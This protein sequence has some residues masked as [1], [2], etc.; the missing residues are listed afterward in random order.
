MAPEPYTPVRIIAKE[1]VA[2]HHRAAPAT[3]CSLDHCS[4]P[5]TAHRRGFPSGGRCR[6]MPFTTRF[7]SSRSQSLAAAIDDPLRLR[8]SR[9]ARMANASRG[10][11]LAAGRNWHS[12]D[13]AVLSDIP[14]GSIQSCYCNRVFADKICRKFTEE[15]SRF[16]YLWR[17]Y[18]KGKTSAS[19]CTR[20]AAFFKRVKI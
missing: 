2:A 4:L 9:S 12:R 5:A 18:R 1:D 8:S 11:R 6:W 20:L 14:Q 7:S 19:P 3:I 16:G 10:D 17:A 15:R 13:G